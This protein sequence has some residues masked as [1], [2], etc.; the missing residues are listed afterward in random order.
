L[1]MCN[2]FYSLVI[3]EYNILGR[4][5]SIIVRNVAYWATW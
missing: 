3:E 1:D 5:I 2:N 4:F